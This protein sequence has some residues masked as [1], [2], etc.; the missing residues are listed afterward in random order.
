ME[1]CSECSI[2]SIENSNC[3]LQDGGGGGG[4]LQ[5]G[6]LV[7]V[8]IGGFDNDDMVSSLGHLSRKKAFLQLESMKNILVFTEYGCAIAMSVH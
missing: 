3:D 2:A 1:P 6:D 7:I 8:V 5:T 4:E